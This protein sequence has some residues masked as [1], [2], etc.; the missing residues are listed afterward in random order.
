MTCLR[1]APM[2]RSSAS[3]RLRWATRIEKVLMMMNTPTI[4]ETAA[5]TSRKVC[6]KPRI[7]SRLSLF[8]LT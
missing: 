3:S 4:R 7:S 1:E 6:R 8:F 2:A 5:K